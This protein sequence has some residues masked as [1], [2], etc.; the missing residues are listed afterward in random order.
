MNRPTLAAAL[1]FVAIP[2]TAQAQVARPNLNSVRGIDLSNLSVAGFV[3]DIV[4]NSDSGSQRDQALQRA[5]AIRRARALSAY[6]LRREERRRNALELRRQRAI[7][8]TP[9]TYNPGF[10][11]PPNL[12]N[13]SFLDTQ[14]GYVVGQNL[15]RHVNQTLGR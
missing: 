8:R 2:C 7:H 3:S 15:R 12:H 6:R 4:V 5:E 14:G 9:Y 13:Y 10:V 11:L 1:L